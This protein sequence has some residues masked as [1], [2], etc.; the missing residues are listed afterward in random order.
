MYFSVGNF[1]KI[2]LA[3]LTQTPNKSL[4]DIVRPVNSPGTES[5]I[6]WLTLGSKIWTRNIKCIGVFA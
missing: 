1:W 5:Y 3:N 2:N 4:C 6:I